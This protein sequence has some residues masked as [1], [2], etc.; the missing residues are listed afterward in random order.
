MKM[1]KQGYPA[2]IM[3]GNVPARVHQS[4]IGI[5]VRVLGVKEINLDRMQQ[6]RSLQNITID[7]RSTVCNP[8][9]LP[10]IL[11]SNARSVCHPCRVA[12]QRMQC[13]EVVLQISPMS[14][15]RVPWKG[16]L[17]LSACRQYLEA[18]DKVCLIL[19]PI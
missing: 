1:A 6:V 17:R 5:L 10:Y 12:Q 2:R 4:L 15:D 16:L 7:L 19:G 11:I 13:A 3:V 8:P 18:L 14:A 9:F